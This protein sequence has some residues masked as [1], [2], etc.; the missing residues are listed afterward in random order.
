[1]TELSL[2]EELL[3]V[4]LDDEKGTDTADWGS[5]VEAGLAGA[6]LLELVTAGCLGEEDGKLVPS[7]AGQ[8]ADPLAA[9]ALEAIGGDDKRRDAKGWVGRLP[10]ELDPLRDRVAAGLVERGVLDEQRHKRL[11]L[12]ETTRYPELDPEPEQRLRES[13]T[14]V[15]AGGREP[16]AHE[17]MLVSLLHAHDLIKRVVPKPDR[18]D[19]RKRAKQI[20]EGDAIGSAVGSTVSDVQAATMVAVTAA[21]IAAGATASGGDGG[22]GG[23]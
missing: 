8:P 19:A 2:H 4:A 16:A 5:G 14:D 6:L 13:L 23:N 3:L 11:G 20:A 21:T 1:M 7:G 10:K 9:A 17:A 18:R 15:L 12:F 22:G